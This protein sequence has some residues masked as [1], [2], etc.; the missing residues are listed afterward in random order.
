MDNIQLNSNIGIQNARSRLQIRNLKKVKDIFESELDPN[1][2]KDLCDL[3]NSYQ[4][5]L[6]RLNSANN[7]NQVHVIRDE[8]NK[9]IIKNGMVE[10]MHNRPDVLEYIHRLP[11]EK[12]D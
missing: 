8:T 2:Y 10:Y 4:F 6:N 9:M 11:E 12:D 3:I 7:M 1:L 5:T